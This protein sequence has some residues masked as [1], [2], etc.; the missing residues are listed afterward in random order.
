M[1]ARVVAVVVAAL[2]VVSLQVVSATTSADDDKN[3]YCDPNN[4]TKLDYCKK[5][6]TYSIDKSL[7]V[8][9]IESLIKNEINTF[10][11]TLQ[12]HPVNPSITLD[13]SALDLCVEARKRMSCL[14]RLPY[15]P[16]VL[17]YV[18]FPCADVCVEYYLRCGFQ[19]P[20]TDPS[21]SVQYLAQQSDR[22][23]CGTLPKNNCISLSFISSK[24]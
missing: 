9:A 1:S 12:L 8:K 4:S 22:G 16:S 13:P 23:F 3:L 17:D 2:L 18:Q 14:S 6:V 10:N 15:C 21:S 24:N 19:P 20:E 11:A 7:D 5:Y